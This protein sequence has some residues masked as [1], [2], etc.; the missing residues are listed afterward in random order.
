MRQ[1][2]SGELRRHLSAGEEWALLDLREEGAF[3]SGHLLL[4]A[5]VPLSRLEILLAD[6]V[7]RKQTPV[8]LGGGSAL[9][10]CAADR[11]AALGYEDVSVYPGDVADWRAAGFETF[12][13][14]HSAR[15]DELGAW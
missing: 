4:A 15:G 7:P 9:A 5:C 2:S 11:L 10:E 14:I 12:T 13:G 1:I 8:V 6:L 3:S